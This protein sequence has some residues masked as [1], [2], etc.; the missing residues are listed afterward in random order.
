MSTNE[1]PVGPS[2]DQPQGTTPPPPP[3]GGYAAPPPPGGYAAP[4]PGGYAAPPPPGG[5]AAPP[6][7]GGYGAPPQPGQ[8]FTPPPTP[9]T[10]RP[11]EL[12]DRFVARLID[13]VILGVVFGIL[14]A[15]FGAMFLRG[16]YHSTGEL[17]LFWL[18]TAVISSAVYVGYFAYLESSRGATIGKQVLKLK[19]VGPD[20]VSNPTME[21]AVRRNIWLAT[22]LLNII[23]IFGSFLSGVAS[24]VAVIMIA[25]GINGDPV[26]R[27]AWH[28]RFA[29]GTR[30]LK[31][32]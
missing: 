12:I 13:G 3:P 25:V 4:P 26:N 30:V 32:G 24:L 8:Q 20:G 2:A 27:Q 28:D 21:Q 5:Y 7:P 9:G 14:Y 31:I 19:V 18:F 15:V 16:Y 10:P 11:G 1:P 17:F 23:P 22:N 6:P 29:G